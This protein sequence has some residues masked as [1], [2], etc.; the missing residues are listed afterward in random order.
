L[1]GQCYSCGEYGNL[2]RFCPHGNGKSKGKGKEQTICYNCGFPGHI[3]ANCPKG[4]GK[5]ATAAWLNQGQGKGVTGGQ[6]NIGSV[7]Q[8]IPPAGNPPDVNH[9]EFTP[10][11]W[12]NSNQA[13]EADFGG[14]WDAAI[15]EVSI[16]NE[17]TV[18]ARKSR[19]NRDMRP[20]RL[21]CCMGGNHL[22]SIERAGN[23]VKCINEVTS[24]NGTWE[25]VRVT[26]D[27]GAVDSMG[28]TTMATDVKIKDTPASRTG[29]KY[30]AAN[31]TS[32]DN[33][34]EKAIQ[35]VT[36]QVNKVG[37]T[38]HIANV[39]KPLGAVR[40]MLAVGN[41]VVRNWK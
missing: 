20:L 22:H 4:K 12:D 36:K 30:R 3:A 8:S 25:K 1:Q 7:Q 32:I 29:L 26:I 41:K 15:N 21:N 18:V 14:S 27:S 38:F 28:P 23:P 6:W 11:I 5:G 35:R 37:M 31:G 19:G 17:W 33:L 24:D 2:A 40:A 39:T 13:I 10:P 16:G 34:G 9:A